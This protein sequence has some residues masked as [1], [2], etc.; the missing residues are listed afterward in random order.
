MLDRRT[1]EFSILVKQISKLRRDLLKR[2]GKVLL[3]A[4]GLDWTP[5][6]KEQKLCEAFIVFFVAELETYLESVVERAIV[7]YRDG[8][9]NSG[10]AECS[11]ATSYIEAIEEKTRR[12][13]KNNNTSWKKTAEF[14]EFVG[15]SQRVFP[16]GLWDNIDQIT[17]DRGEIAHNSCGIRLLKD[18]RLTIQCSRDILRRLAIFDRDFVAWLAIRSIELDR[19]KRSSLT[20]IPGMGTIRTGSSVTDDHLAT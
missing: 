12:W 3:P 15:F 10:L 4:R 5:S 9:L 19:F 1:Q 20:F 16:D 8:L 6:D 14:W 7:V 11:G 18:P 2:D 17:L 13:Q